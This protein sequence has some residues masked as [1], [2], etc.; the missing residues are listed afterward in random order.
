MMPGAGRKRTLRPG[1]HLLKILNQPFTYLPLWV[2]ACGSGSRMSVEARIAEDD[3]ARIRALDSAWTA[4]AARRDLDAM[5]SIYAPDA[6][7]L[8]PGSPAIV[9]RDAI[10]QFYEGLIKRFP[11]FAHQFEPAS[12]VVAASRDLA[13]VRGSYSFTADT[14]KPEQVQIGKFIGIWKRPNGDWRLSL[15]ISNSDTPP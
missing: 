11:R 2:T 8:L 9:G 5:M 3:A 7:E 10:R 14:L 4:A 1:F 15:N 12:I 13:V 6:E